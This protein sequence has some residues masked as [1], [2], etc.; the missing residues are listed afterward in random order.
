[1]PPRN[2]AKSPQRRFV[3]AEASDVADGDAKAERISKVMA[4]AGVASRRDIERMIMDG[5]VKL[6][7]KLLDKPGRQRDAGETRSKWTAF[8]SAASSARGC[9]SITSPPVS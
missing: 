8:R 4:R 1:M 7:G 6:N 2:P 5:R 9:G 3:K